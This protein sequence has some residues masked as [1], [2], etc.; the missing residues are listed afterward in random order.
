[1]SDLETLE[2]SYRDAEGKFAFLQWRS[3]EL[4]RQLDKLPLEMLDA[5]GKEQRE[6]LQEEFN[7]CVMELLTLPPQLEEMEK[8]R[9]LALLEWRNA[10][11]GYLKSKAETI[12]HEE[13]TPLQ[14]R[15]NELAK[16]L[17]VDPG[18]EEIRLAL[19]QARQAFSL[20]ENHYKQADAQAAIFA[21]SVAHEVGVSLSTPADW[22]GHARKRGAEARGHAVLKIGF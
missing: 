1:M 15:L 20:A 12:F 6:G 3:E 18:N 10:Q 2:R 5:E 11:Y 17:E 21:N 8:R 9:V 4:R 16:H 14:A 13:V 7:H 19:D 22:D